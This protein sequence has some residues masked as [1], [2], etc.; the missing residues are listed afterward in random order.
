[1]FG[2]KTFNFLSALPYRRPKKTDPL[3]A[4][5]RTGAIVLG[6]IAIALA[7]VVLPFW[8]VSDR[9]YS[10]ANSGRD[11]LLVAQAAVEKLDF[12]SAYTHVQAAEDDFAR[13]QSELKKLEPLVDFPYIGP[14]LK[15]ADYLLSTGITT[16]SAVTDML[17]VGR[18]IV[19]IARETEGLSGQLSGVM[20]GPATLFKDL[21][22]GQKRDILAKLSSSV[23]KVREALVKTDLAIASFDDIPTEGV[24]TQFTE[25]LAPFR[26]K[27]VSMR[28]G[29][30]AALPIMEIAPGI[31]G[32]PREQ[33]YLFFFQNNTELRPSGGFIGV[34]G[35]VT[36]KDAEL[37]S[38]VTNDVYALDGPSE[39]QPRP[40]PPEPI[41][42]YIGVEKWYLRDANW[43]PDFT[44]SAETMK[45]FFR[46]EYAVINGADKVPEIDGVIA[47]TPTFA[48]DLVRIVG[49][50]TIDGTTFTP[51]NLV[52]QLEFEVEKGFVESGIAFHQRKDIVGKLVEEVIRRLSSLPLSRIMETLAVVDRN[53][54]EGHVLFNAT[55]NDL[56]SVILAHDW[57]GRLKA[58]FGDYLM[59]VDANLASLKT[60]AVMKRSVHYVIAPSGSGYE[61]RVA[62]TY[63]NR[64]SFTW[65][66]TRY[67]TYARAYVPAGSE[68][69]GWSGAMENDKLKD[70]ARRPGKADVVDELGKRT[71]GAF[72]S[73]E[74]GEKR[75]L[76]FRYKLAPSVVNAI[77]AGKYRLDVEK[78]P[79]TLSPG[80]TLDLDF[81][82]NLTSAV[83]AED[84][85]EWG[86]ARYRFNTDLRIDRLFEIGL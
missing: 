41:R 26:A 66:S 2:K 80:L 85:K 33:H 30:E 57:G 68:L 27:L 84:R 73:I 36:V 42:K 52:D 38:V 13:A 10:L 70:P 86:D 15:A 61:G 72:I 9:V 79:G 34:I 1:M 65:K 37:A 24:A 63:E 51:E 71:F 6:I 22:P 19:A 31:L 44:V 3:H 8:F 17:G 14:H 7:V 49:S 54:D 74:P 39:S 56:Q 82:K 35:S 69:V 11:E 32:Y 76:E 28:D 29:L 64:G 58:T 47:I 78:Q 62:I 23:P 20:P 67:R 4:G 45:R 5:L 81:G 55:S 25:S 12:D 46:E 50:I 16:S 48:Q 43:S 60:D 21:T 53:L 83:P 40:V 18:D 59:V 77:K 75:T